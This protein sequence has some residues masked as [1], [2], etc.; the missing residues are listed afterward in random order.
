MAKTPPRE[1]TR[2][3]LLDQG[4]AFLTEYGYHGSG[5]QDI[6]ASVQVPKARFTITSPA[7]RSSARR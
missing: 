4:V 2:A 6:L 1:L 3:K 5:L 7:R